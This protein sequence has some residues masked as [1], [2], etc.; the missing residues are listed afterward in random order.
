MPTIEITCNTNGTI[1]IDLNGTLSGN[2]A[3]IFCQGEK[4]I[5]IYP[6]LMSL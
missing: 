5:A 1:K 2:R 6:Y 3:R 4:V